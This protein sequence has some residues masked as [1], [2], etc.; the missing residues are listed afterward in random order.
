MPAN[1]TRPL[2]FCSSPAVVTSTVFPSKNKRATSITSSKWPARKRYWIAWHQPFSQ[3]RKLAMS[4]HIGKPSP[5]ISAA[6]HRQQEC[7]LLRICT[8]AEECS[9]GKASEREK[10]GGEESHPSTRPIGDL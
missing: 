10:S 4:W 5:R 9:P 2:W 6:T 8:K 3:C 1:T 7:C